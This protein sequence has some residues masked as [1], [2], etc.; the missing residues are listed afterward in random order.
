[1]HELLS[2]YS[3][4]YSYTF[5]LRIHDLKSLPS[6]ILDKYFDAN[7]TEVT[8]HVFLVQIFSMQNVSFGR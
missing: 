3:F 4:K 6:Y 1:M 5:I 2:I 8:V 7:I